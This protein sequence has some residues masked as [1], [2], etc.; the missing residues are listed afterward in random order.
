M[1]HHRHL[2]DKNNQK[3]SIPLTAEQIEEAKAKKKERNKN[4]QREKK[5]CRAARKKG[6]ESDK[7]G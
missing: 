3:K 2:K 7:G 5:N 1:P 6:K 4:K